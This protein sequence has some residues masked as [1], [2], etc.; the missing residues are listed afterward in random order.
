MSGKNAKII[1]F[2]H[3]MFQYFIVFAYPLENKIHLKLLKTTQTYKKQ[4]NESHL[5]VDIRANSQKRVTFAE[6]SEIRIMHTWQFAYNQAR[7]DKWQQAARDRSR[8]EKRIYETGK[9][10]ALSLENKYLTFF[11]NI[12][13]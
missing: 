6:K 8:F 10:I 2:E 7:K 13:R 12:N 9:I 11:Y 1:N 4:Q 5:I 3:G